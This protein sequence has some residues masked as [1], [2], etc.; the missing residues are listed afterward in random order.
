M[1]KFDKAEEK[2][3]RIIENLIKN[4]CVNYEFQPTASKIDLF[5]TGLTDMAAIE[6]K[7]RERYTAEQ[8]EGFG[9][10]YI[11]ETKYCSLTATT[12][13]GYKPIFCTIFKDIIVMWD[14]DGMNLQ[15]HDEYLDNTCVIDTGKSK[16]SVS[17]LHISAATA[18]YQTELYKNEQSSRENSQGKDS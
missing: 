9:G 7:D 1:N 4:K 15:F 8:I 11:K 6:I 12:L 14:L 10:M 18:T 13:N 5:V 17:F 3:R 2:G 16:Q